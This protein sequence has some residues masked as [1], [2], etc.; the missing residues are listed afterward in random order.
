MLL[1]G[2][3]DSLAGERTATAAFGERIEV[4]EIIFER[5]K[6]FG[7]KRNERAAAA[8]FLPVPAAGATAWDTPKRV[9]RTGQVAAAYLVRLDA[10]AEAGAAC[11]A[12]R[13]PFAIAQ[14]APASARTEKAMAGRLLPQPR[15]AT[16][17]PLPLLLPGS[18]GPS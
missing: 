1:V 13:P 11:W 10:G 12:T 8:N 3:F 5:K 17:L 6:P 18:G 7:A 4:G 2:H 9:A 14:A 16:G 15:P